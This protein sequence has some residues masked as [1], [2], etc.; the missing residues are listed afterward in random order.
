LSYATNIA[1]LLEKRF[2]Y[3]QTQALVAIVVAH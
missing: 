3:L 1:Y 2:K